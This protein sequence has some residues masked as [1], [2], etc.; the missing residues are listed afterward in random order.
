MGK[1]KKITFIVLG[2]VGLV[3]IGIICWAVYFFWIMDSVTSDY[4]NIM[5]DYN[6]AYE[7]AMEEYED[8]MDDY[9]YYY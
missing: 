9:D 5:D 1:G 7:D 6:D 3:V 8:A 4:E 2:S